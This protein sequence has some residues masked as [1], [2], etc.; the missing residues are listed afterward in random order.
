MSK[1]QERGQ[2]F[3]NPLKFNIGENTPAEMVTEHNLRP[4][5]NYGYKAAPPKINNKSLSQVIKTADLTLD[6]AVM[7]NLELQGA[8]DYA[9]GSNDDAFIGIALGALVKVPAN[10]NAG[11]YNAKF[12]QNNP[13]ILNNAKVGRSYGLGYLDASGKAVP[14]TKGITNYT[15][16]INALSRLGVDVKITYDAEDKKVVPPGSIM[17]IIRLANGYA[18]SIVS[19]RN[20]RTKKFMRVGG[21][22]HRQ[23]LSSNVLDEDEREGLVLAARLFGFGGVLFNQYPTDKELSDMAKIA[24]LLKNPAQ[25]QRGRYASARNIA[26]HADI[27]LVPGA[28]ARAHPN[29]VRGDANHTDAIMNELQRRS[30]G[31]KSHPLQIASGFRKPHERSGITAYAPRKMDGSTYDGDQSQL[32]AQ[33]RVPLSAKGQVKCTLDVAHSGFST[34]STDDLYATRLAL[35]QRKHKSKAKGKFGMSVAGSQPNLV[36]A[37]FN[38]AL[39]RDIGDAENQRN[40]YGKNGRYA[41]ANGKGFQETFGND[42]YDRIDE[43]RQDRL[44]AMQMMNEHSVKLNPK[45]NRLKIVQ[46]KKGFGSVKTD[47]NNTVGARNARDLFGA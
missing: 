20:P 41:T 24:E 4:G 35:T 6:V 1:Q 18:D 19:I 46:G 43:D 25:V 37:P 38:P 31:A 17:H 21:D 3:A 32:S 16:A 45:D 23:L 30:E 40:L 26:A 27:Y 29:G 36:C 44:R 8:V 39:A 34:N 12:V 15:Q 22:A 5:I 13:N 10:E 2:R 14:F 7:I 33:G 47:A 42:V 11:E 9:D 28:D